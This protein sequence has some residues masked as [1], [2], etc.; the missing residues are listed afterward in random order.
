MLRK[1]LN[2]KAM[3]LTLA[4]SLSAFAGDTKAPATKTTPDTKTTTKSDEK[5][6]PSKKDPDQIGSR[7]V[8]K[9]L[10]FYSLEKEIALGKGLA[11]DVE[12]QAKIVDD[13]LIAELRQPRGPEPGAQL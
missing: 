3:A 4:T 5:K 6:K 13:P 2:S 11:T 8:G 12:R 9:G 7:D 1:F 10:N